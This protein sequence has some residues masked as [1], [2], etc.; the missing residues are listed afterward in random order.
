MNSMSP[1]S[2]TILHM[3]AQTLPVE[4][5]II[6]T[7]RQALT[8]TPEALFAILVGSR[9][10]GSATENSDWDIAIQWQH[11]DA[12]QRIARHELMRHR[13]A[14]LLGLPN[15]QIDLIDLS[16]ARLAMR[17]L[18]AEEGYL[19]VA[20]DELAWTKFL[21]R[22]WRELEDFYWEHTHAA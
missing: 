19:L 2:P 17:A 14:S 7:L 21:T 22:T 4:K 18:V 16:N 3:P 20:N 12:L 11:G 13:L 15:E 1:V 6:D 8:D 9:A 10:N 5:V